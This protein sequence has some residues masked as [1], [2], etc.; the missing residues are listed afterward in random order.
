MPGQILGAFDKAFYINLDRRTDKRERMER[1]L[2]E[3]GIGAERFPA[4]EHKE[5]VLSIYGIWMDSEYYRK[6]YGCLESH[7]KVLE[8]ALQRNAS[9]VLVMEDDILLQKPPDACKEMLAGLGG[10]PWDAFWFY[11]GEKG[12]QEGRLR[13]LE[14]PSWGAYAYAINGPAIPK[15]IDLIYKSY[16]TMRWYPLDSIYVSFL[17]GNIFAPE[18]D[19]MGHD[20]GFKSDIR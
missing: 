6:T 20:F 16:E 12:K 7:L 3:A 9:S 10:V 14:R 13:R 8:T 2:K 15:V 1:V 18:V 19:L 11:G 4:I 17:R 5:K